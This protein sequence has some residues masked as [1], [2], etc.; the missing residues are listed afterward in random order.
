MGAG[1]GAQAATSSTF[2]HPAARQHLDEVVD[3]LVG[4]ARCRLPE[5]DYNI[6]VGPGTEPARLPC[7]RRHAGA[8]S[9]LLDWVDRA[10]RSPSRPY[11]SRT[12]LGRY[13]HRLRH[14]LP[15]P[16]PL[17]TSDQQDFIRYPPIAAAAPM[18]IAPEQAAVWAYPSRS[19]ATTRSPSRF[20]MPCSA[21]STSPATST[22]SARSES[23]W[24]RMPSALQTVQARPRDGG[25]VWPSGCPVGGQLGRLRHVV[26][27]SQVTWL[28]G[29]AVM[30][31]DGART[32]RLLASTP[33]LWRWPC[34]LPICPGKQAAAQVLYPFLR[35]AP[36]PI[37]TCRR[38][39]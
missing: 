9:R 39:S 24:W 6:N 13:A 34:R 33:A 28:F 14:A 31:G 22:G 8:Q 19:G 5:I 38:A 17:S 11:Q 21:G 32:D 2:A 30:W 36:W 10:P 20:A 7:R 23:N 15:F 25:T 37:G 27:L 3:F 1:R 29:A 4:G 12:A 16:A 26:A 35:V 18:A